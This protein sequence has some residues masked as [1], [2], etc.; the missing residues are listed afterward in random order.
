MPG[1]PRRVAAGAVLAFPK[2][3][4][5]AHA[6]SNPGPEPARVLVVSTMRFPDVAEHLDTGALLA[7]TGP[8]A[9][10]VFPAGADVPFA[11]AVLRAMQAE[12]E[13]E[14]NAEA[15]QAAS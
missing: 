11:D 7:I 10:R 3:E 13:V 6:V 12:A 2:G 4:G 1:G 15:E 5:G 9:G 8:A 14:A